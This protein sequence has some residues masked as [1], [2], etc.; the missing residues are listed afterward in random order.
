MRHAHATSHPT[1]TLS[2]RDPS[3]SRDKL[4]TLAS[5]TGRTKSFL[6]AE[7]IKCYLATQLWQVNAIEQAIKKAD[8]N[9]SAFIEHQTVA[10]W[11]SSWGDESTEQEPF[12]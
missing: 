8:S 7:A 3:E 11:L 5:V 6:A 4:E 10:T 9:T 12:K 1:V 2:V